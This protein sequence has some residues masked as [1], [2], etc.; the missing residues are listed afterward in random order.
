MFQGVYDNTDTDRYRLQHGPCV[1]PFGR[2]RPPETPGGPGGLPAGTGAG[3]TP[4]PPL[5]S[6]PVPSQYHMSQPLALYIAARSKD[7]SNKAL[8]A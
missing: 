5:T 8:P 1:W 7:S 4:S 2:S 3:H 6:N